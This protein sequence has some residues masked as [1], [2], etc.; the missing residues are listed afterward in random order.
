M[1][2]AICN[3][4]SPFALDQYEINHG[5]YTFT[6]LKAREVYGNRITAPDIDHQEPS[7]VSGNY[8]LLLYL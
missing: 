2:R 4:H 3:T 6:L 1:Y 8:G 7:P 5:N